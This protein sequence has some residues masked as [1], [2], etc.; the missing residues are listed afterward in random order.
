M[1]YTHMVIV[2]MNLELI[3]AQQN[4]VEL[5]VHLYLDSASHFCSSRGANYVWLQLYNCVTTIIFLLFLFFIFRYTHQSM[6]C[7]HCQDWW[8]LLLV[9]TWQERTTLM[10]PINWYVQCFAMTIRSLRKD[11]ILCGTVMVIINEI[12][13]SNI[14]EKK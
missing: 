7:H 6:C 1:K 3:S 2:L 11:N 5:K 10:Y 4:V 13:N 12:C 8:S 14:Q 9:R